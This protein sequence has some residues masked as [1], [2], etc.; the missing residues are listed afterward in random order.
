M[1]KGCFKARKKWQYKKNYIFNLKSDGIL[2][3]DKT[4]ILKI[5]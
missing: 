2:Y 3:T 5:I 4:N 1:I